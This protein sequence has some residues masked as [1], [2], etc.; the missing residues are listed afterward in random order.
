MHFY[1]KDKPFSHSSKIINTWSEIYVRME[2]SSKENSHISLPSI[3]KVV[4]LRY[5]ARIPNFQEQF[6]NPGNR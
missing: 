2:F 4:H 6:C 5:Q 1:P 3:L